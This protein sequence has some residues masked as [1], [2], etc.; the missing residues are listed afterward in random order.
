MTSTTVVST[1]GGSS[2]LEHVVVPTQSDHWLLRRGTLMSVGCGSQLN[3]YRNIQRAVG[4]ST[5]SSE[6]D[7]ISDY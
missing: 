4:K 6:Q 3:E 2:W 5:L 7:H 1:C